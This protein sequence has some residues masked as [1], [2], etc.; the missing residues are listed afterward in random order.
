MIFEI[1][2]LFY[3]VYLIKV[4]IF[5]AEAFLEKESNSNKRVYIKKSEKVNLL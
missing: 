2:D 5:R 4:K 3:Q 1:T